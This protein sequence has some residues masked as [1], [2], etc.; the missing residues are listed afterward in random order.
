M[1]KYRL[2]YVS[3]HHS[4]GLPAYRA[5][6][7]VADYVPA[8]KNQFAC[9]AFMLRVQLD[10]SRFNASTSFEFYVRRAKH[11][12]YLYEDVPSDF[13]GKVRFYAKFLKVMM[14]G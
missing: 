5:C 13:F 4:N 3:L 8:I 1:K 12:G 10:A 14:E 9:F 11:Y 2:D 6:T 7:T